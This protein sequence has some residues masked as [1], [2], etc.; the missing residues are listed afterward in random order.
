MYNKEQYIIQPYR[1][2]KERRSVA[3]IVPSKVVKTLKIDPATNLVL[4]KIRA[5]D[6]LELKILREDQL[7]GKEEK[8]VMPVEKFPR[9]D[10]QAPLKFVEVVD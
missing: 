4:L 5:P 1:V 3:M 7:I 6:G 8:K 9:L 2:G 10:Q